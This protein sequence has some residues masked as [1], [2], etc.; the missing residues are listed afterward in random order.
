M[1][2]LLQFINAFQGRCWRLLEMMETFSSG[3]PP[4]PITTHRLSAKKASKI[5][6]LGE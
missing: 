5:K 2:P 4:K 6:R 3:F 1:K